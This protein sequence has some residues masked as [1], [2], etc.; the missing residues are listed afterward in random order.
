MGYMMGIP[1]TGKK[2]VIH[3]IDIIRL[4]D[5]QY[6]EHW[7]MSNLPEVMAEISRKD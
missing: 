5:G 2:V 4:K 7:G 3:V 6:V 1:P